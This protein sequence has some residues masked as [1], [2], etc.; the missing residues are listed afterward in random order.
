MPSRW[1]VVDLFSGAGGM[2]YG[3]HA[4]PSFEVIAAVD[5]QVGKPSSPAGTLE[6]NHTYE[7]NMG[8][9]P[10]GANLAAIDPA[11]LRARTLSR[12]RRERPTV[13]ISCAPCTGFSRTM[14]SNHLV[15]DPR[16]SLVARS[17]DFV[18]AMRPSIF[19]MENA[20]ELIRGNF[21]HHYERLC[22]QLTELG[23]TVHGE[24]HVL[25][26]F[27]LPQQRERALLVAVASGLPLRTLS[28][29]W[30]GFSVHPPATHVR[31][32]IGHLPPIAAG[33]A[34]ASDLLHV[35]PNFNA[36]LTRQRIRMIPH[37]GGSWADLRFAKGGDAV[38]TPAMHRYIAAGDLGS[39]PDVYGRMAWDRPSVTIKRECAHVGNG[40]YAHPEQDRLCTVREMS[41]LQGFPAT[42]AF[43]AKSVANMY[44]HI[45]DAVP[46]MI[47]FQLAH[48]CEWILS[49]TRPAMHDIVLPG[50]SLRAADITPAIERQLP[51][52]I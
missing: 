16:N 52:A 4:H 7:A 3:F 46:P 2:S 48:V 45:G 8:V 31:R 9:A 36:P 30:D 17:A 15:D 42:Y 38:L 51:L 43:T 29:L 34:H 11:E 23:Y 14:S 32:A 37:D 19:L 24:I 41:L 12:G 6:C 27:G 33:R 49:G 35:S 10:I 5:A 21:K 47:S 28:D 44:R 40:R 50:T 25:S 20:R 18:A 26:E 39:H 13:L 1:T 22:D